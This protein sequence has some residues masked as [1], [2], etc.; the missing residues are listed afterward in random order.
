MEQEFGDHLVATNVLVHAAKQQNP[1]QRLIRAAQAYLENESLL[2][3]KPVGFRGN[4]E[5][6]FLKISLDFASKTDRFSLKTATAV[7]VEGYRLSA[8]EVEGLL[9]LV[10]DE[11]VK[12]MKSSID[13]EKVRQRLVE[14][15]W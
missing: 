4:N 15:L 11:P 8:V 10:V 3:R 14:H 2:M 13:H 1:S 12:P 9:N 5:S 6:C 7:E